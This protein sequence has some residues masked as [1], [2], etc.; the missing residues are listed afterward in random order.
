MDTYKVWFKDNRAVS[1]EVMT[2]P[3][4]KDNKHFD[5]RNGKLEIDWYVLECDN[6]KVAMEVA[7]KVVRKIWGK[8][9]FPE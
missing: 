8:L 1:A 9:L 6:A 2:M 4:P 7:E 3:L 5:V